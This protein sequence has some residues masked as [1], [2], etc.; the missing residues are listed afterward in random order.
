MR[1]ACDNGQVHEQIGSEIELIPEE[2]HTLGALEAS[3]T[4]P[5]RQVQGARII[6]LA[7]KAQPNSAISVVVGMNPCRVGVWRRRF[8]EER[9]AGLGD[10]PPPQGQSHFELGA[11]SEAGT[12]GNP[13][14]VGW[15][16]AGP[17]A[18]LGPSPENANSHRF[19]NL[20]Q[21]KCPRSSLPR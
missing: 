1:A 20:G 3:R 11:V 15:S 2:R 9:L 17:G 5:V 12:I 18:M 6:L 7:A 21:V 19:G 16:P 10:R 4:A 14:V 13:H 8:A